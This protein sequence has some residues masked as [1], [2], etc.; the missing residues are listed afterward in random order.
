MASSGV[1]KVILSLYRDD[2]QGSAFNRHGGRVPVDMDEHNTMEKACRHLIDVMGIKEQV[3]KSRLGSFDLKL[4]RLEK[5]KEN[6]LNQKKGKK[7]KSC[8]CFFADGKRHKEC[9]LDYCM[10]CS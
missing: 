1:V 6:A 5:I 8:C 7:R 9:K 3:E 2:D 4:F 10:I